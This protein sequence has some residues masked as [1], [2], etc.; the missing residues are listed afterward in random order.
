[1]AKKFFLRT[2]KLFKTSKKQHF[3][4]KTKKHQE[5][6]LLKINRINRSIGEKINRLK[7]LE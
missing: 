6:S 5:L 2:V 4:F 7:I 3:L 1:M